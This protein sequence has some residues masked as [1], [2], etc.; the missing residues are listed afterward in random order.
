MRSNAAVKT[1]F[2]PRYVT[3]ISAC[4]IQ[5]VM[6][7]G[8]FAYGLIFTQLEETFGWSRTLLSTANSMVVLVMGAAAIG[9][10]RVNDRFGL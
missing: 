3:V 9:V 5:A 10:G 1:S 7:G 2:D 6:I 4:V 8:F